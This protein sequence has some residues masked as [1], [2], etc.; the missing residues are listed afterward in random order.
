MMFGKLAG[1]FIGSRIAGDDRGPRGAVLGYGIAAL[2]R[3]GLGPLIAALAI[4][5]GARKLY[6]ERA[7]L[8]R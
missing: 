4:G 2:G 3:R 7:R 1:A 5:W 6:R 8:V